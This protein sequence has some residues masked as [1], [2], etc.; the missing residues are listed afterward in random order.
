MT[1]ATWFKEESAKL[2]ETMP[3]G[4]KMERDLIRHWRQNSP[5]MVKRLE[6]QK[7]LAA[8]AHVLVDRALEAAT[9]YKRAGMAPTDAREQAEREWLLKEPESDPSRLP[10]DPIM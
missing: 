5:R 10:L 2:E 9:D 7:A 1:T 3:R 6:A 4:S 8:A